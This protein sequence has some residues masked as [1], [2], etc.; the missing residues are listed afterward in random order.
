MNIVHITPASLSKLGYNEIY[1]KTVV[2]AGWGLVTESGDEPKFLQRADVRV[3]TKEKCTENLNA[4]NYT[5]SVINH[6]CTVGKIKPTTLARV[7]YMVLF[8]RH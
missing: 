8:N 2:I 6:F 1:G 7:R 4:F 5:Q 3:I